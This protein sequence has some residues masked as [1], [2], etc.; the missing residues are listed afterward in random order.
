MELFF[1]PIKSFLKVNIKK[2]IK[3]ELD[4][5]VLNLFLMQAIRSV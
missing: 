2:Y 4:I 5:T 1:F 3:F